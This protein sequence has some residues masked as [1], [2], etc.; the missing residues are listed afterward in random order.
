MTPSTAYSR[1]LGDELRGLRE[2]CTGLSGNKLAVKLGWDPSKISTIEHGKAR[3]SEVDLIQF[4]SMCGK[5]IDFLN[6]FKRR[7]ERA[8]DEYFVQVSGNLR[9]VTMAESTAITITSYSPQSIPG[10][11]QIPEYADGLY[12]MTGVVTEERIPTLVQFRTD[13]Q[14]ILRRHDRPTC[15]FFIHEHALQLQVG[16]SE[17]MED[18]YARLLFDTHTIRIVPANAPIAATGCVLW[19]YEKARPIVFSETNLAKVFVQDPGA[20]ARTRLLFDRLDQIA[21]SAEQSRGKL[22]E[23]VSRPREGHDDSGPHLA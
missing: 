17:I 14:A 1:D 9:T 11:V 22:A 20:I 15:L 21:L 3:A 2:T 12:R 18:Q 7:Y 16:S 5:D 10:L 6:D 8:F 4:L 13:R 23:Y 19:E